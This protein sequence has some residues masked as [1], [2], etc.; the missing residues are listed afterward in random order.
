MSPI[1][2]KWQS[3]NSVL[4]SLSVGFW[5]AAFVTFSVSW[6][7]CNVVL[8]VVKVLSFRGKEIKASIH[9]FHDE[10]PIVV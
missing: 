4:V 8:L 9:Q 7:L 3:R 1:V 5:S 10:A 2:R 6:E